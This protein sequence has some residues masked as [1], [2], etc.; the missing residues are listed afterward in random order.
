M[1]D[2]NQTFIEYIKKHSQFESPRVLDCGC[3]FGY[4]QRLFEQEGWATVGVDIS[5][6]AIRAANESTKGDVARMDVDGSLGIRDESFDIVSMF[7]IIEHVESPYRTLQELY[8]VLRPNGV[9]AIHCPNANAIGRFLNRTTWFGDK[10]ETHKYMFTPYSLRFLTERTGF[11]VVG[12]ATPFRP[13]PDW[14]S[15]CRSGLGGAIILIARKPG[16]G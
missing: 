1:K 4:L 3:G 5:S 11:E 10:D 2:A 6:V 14:L 16:N 8:R 12:C 7:D 13:L 9:V 15:L